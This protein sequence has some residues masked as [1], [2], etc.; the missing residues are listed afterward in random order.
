MLFL[1]LFESLG[2]SVRSSISFGPFMKQQPWA[3][4]HTVGKDTGVSPVFRGTKVQT[5]IVQL[6]V[7][8]G[9]LD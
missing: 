7:T 4:P 3:R 2:H 5:G 6:E 1:R 9:T 8:E